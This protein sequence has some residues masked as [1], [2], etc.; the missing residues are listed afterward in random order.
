ML[1]ATVPGYTNSLYRWGTD[2][3]KAEVLKQSRNQVDKVFLFR[4]RLRIVRPY[5]EVVMLLLIVLMVCHDGHAYMS[6]FHLCLWLY[7]S[8]VSQFRLLQHHSSTN[9]PCDTYSIHTISETVLT[10]PYSI[11]TVLIKF[12][13]VLE[14]MHDV[15][16][17]RDSSLRCLST[18]AASLWF[19]PSGVPMKS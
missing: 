18:D 16:L 9:L 11:P 2:T 12:W 6:L 5:N 15:P 3:I 19:G 10:L 17:Q 4:K 7:Y 8:N 14:G 13:S 1:C